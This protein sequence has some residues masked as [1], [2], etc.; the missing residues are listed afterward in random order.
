[1]LI[2]NAGLAAIALLADYSNLDLF[3][4]VMESNLTGWCN[5]HTMPHPI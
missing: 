3:R 1:M 5:A 4:H 2:N